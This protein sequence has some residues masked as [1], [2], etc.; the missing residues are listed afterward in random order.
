MRMV[1]DCAG[2]T[3]RGRSR[4]TN[5]DHYL[6][7]DLIKSVS[8]RDTSLPGGDY[9][10]QFAGLPGKLLVVADGMGGHAGGRRASSLAIETLAKY[11]LNTMHWFFRL[12]E[13]RE[14]DLV[15]E[16][17]AALAECQAAVGAAAATEAGRERMGTTLTL[18]Y[19]L[20]PRAYV[21][22]TGDSRCYL[23]RGGR[24]KRVT[25]DHTMAQKLVD[26]G[27]WTAEEA[28]ESRWNHV[29]WS[30]I[31]NKPAALH[32]DVHRFHL[33]AGDSLLLCTDG[34]TRHVSDDGLAAELGRLPEATACDV[35]RRLVAQAN[36]AGG[37]DNITVVAGH[38][39]PQDPDV[40]LHP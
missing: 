27:V 34:L 36:E 35:V 5:E 25:R 1:C 26:E 18:A 17:K 6:V 40:T 13:N 39:R 11:V 28:A 38:F 8:V 14:D 37:A 29:L 4:E 2:A 20:W 9:M 10:R 30:C 12:Q 24:L 3:D 32:P 19:I 23:H 31:N 22:H 7:A 16:L 21:I 33:E 15:E